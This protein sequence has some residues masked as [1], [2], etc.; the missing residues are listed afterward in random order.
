MKRL[1]ALIPGAKEAIKVFG[2][3]QNQS[4]EQDVAR[5]LR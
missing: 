3:S 1:A 4:A 5:S 2:Y